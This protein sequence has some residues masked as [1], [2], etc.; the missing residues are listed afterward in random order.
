[1]LNDKPLAI[2]MTELYRRNRHQGRIVV[3]MDDLIADMIEI[4]DAGSHCDWQAKWA[5]RDWEFYEQFLK[6]L[7]PQLEMF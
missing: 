3:S 4:S 7:K 5:S 1:M 2:I 6:K